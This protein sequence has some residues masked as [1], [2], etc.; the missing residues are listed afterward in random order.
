MYLLSRLYRNNI[1]LH[2]ECQ[3]EASANS[4]DTPT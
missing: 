3:Q 2:I 1:D 4:S